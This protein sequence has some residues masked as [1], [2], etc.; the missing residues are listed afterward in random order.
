M[1]ERIFCEGRRPFI[2]EDGA[3]SFFNTEYN[4]AYHSR[5][6]PIKEAEHKFVK[7]SALN[8]L[9]LKNKKVKILDLFFG[10]GYNTG[11]ALHC[12]YETAGLPSV[13]IVAVEK[14]PQII[15]QIK[16]L[17]VPEWYSK[18]QALLSK[19]DQ[20]SS[21]SFDNVKIELYLDCVFNVINKLPQK[22]F[23]VIFFDPFSHK[24]APRFWTDDFLTSVFK[25]LSNGG[26]LTTYSGLK[27]IA[28]LANTLG[29]TAKQVEPIG[30]KKGS[31]LI[32]N[33]LYEEPAS[34]CQM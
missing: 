8:E 13:E 30:R 9:I 7:P 28:S 34:T 6:G 3:Q 25:L 31:L 24:T 19:L 21:L 18:W 20:K 10:L 33:Y 4:E 2:G 15:Q 11:V 23:D 1:D 26:T 27:R 12:A 22:Y 5:I 16:E 14:D 32:E 29:L 17:T